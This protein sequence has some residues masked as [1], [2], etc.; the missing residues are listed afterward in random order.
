MGK[1]KATGKNDCLWSTLGEARPA[2]T[3]T[4]IQ[5][6]NASDIPSKCNG[7]CRIV[8]FLIEQ[9]LTCGWEDNFTGGGYPD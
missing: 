1:D 3:P 5:G 2:G 6:E 7:Q 4:I 8:G 9:C